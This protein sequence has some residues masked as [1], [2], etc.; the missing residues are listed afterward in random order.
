M[1][2]KESFEKL[3]EAKARMKNWDTL[4]ERDAL[5]EEWKQ[6]IRNLVP[7]VGVKCTIVYYSDYRAATVTTVLSERKVAVRFNN[8]KC[9]DYFA[10]EYE[11]LPELEGEERIFTKRSN[12]K[13][14]AEGQL[15]RDGVRLAL[16][17]QRHYIN[18]EY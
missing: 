6:A 3:R 11:I 16:H 9:L 4:A 5:E 14:I 18:P 13:W 7:E 10:G 8:T 2:S 17:Y 15:S 1:T 12:G